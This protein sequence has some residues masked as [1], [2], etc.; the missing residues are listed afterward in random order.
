MTPST[1]SII[2]PR[3]MDNPPMWTVPTAPDRISELSRAF[4]ESPIGEADTLAEAKALAAN[5]GAENVDADASLAVHYQFDRNIFDCHGKP[6]RYRIGDWTK[7]STPWAERFAK[8]SE[9]DI[10][11]ATE[12]VGAFVDAHS[13]SES[14]VYLTANRQWELSEIAGAS[15]LCSIAVQT[16]PDGIDTAVVTGIAKHEAAREAHAKGVALDLLEIADG[17]GRQIGAEIFSCVS[18]LDTLELRDIGFVLESALE[19]TGTDALRNY[20]HDVVGHELSSRPK[21][22]MALRMPEPDGF[23]DMD[24]EE[25][26][27]VLG[28]MNARAV[29]YAKHFNETVLLGVADGGDLHWATASPDSGVAEQGTNPV[30][31][32]R[33]HA[34]M[35]PLPNEVFDGKWSAQDAHE[36]GFPFENCDLKQSR[37]LIEAANV[38]DGSYFREWSNSIARH[39]D[40][41][42]TID[43]AVIPVIQ[44]LNQ[45]DNELA[46]RLLKSDVRERTTINRGR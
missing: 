34:A 19:G 43:A 41:T 20:I 5:Y 39:Y 7:L 40:D 10:K 12:I 28:D 25:W 38:G 33:I 13:R 44:N 6:S 31:H 11:G 1:V 27:K 18:G 17:C 36:A 29:M 32:A 8:M 26:R 37:E 3:V 42:F 23:R 9:A 24:D 35:L 45:N 2:K 15:T 16:F 22:S 14:L 21:W 30:L 46:R 4:C